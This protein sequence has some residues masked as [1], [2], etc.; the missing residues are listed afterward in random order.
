MDNNYEEK[1]FI[2]VVFLLSSDLSMLFLTLSGVMHWHDV[3]LAE[4]GHGDHLHGLAGHR[5]HLV[6]LHE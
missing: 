3:L 1:M 2:S 6:Q 5:S 4:H